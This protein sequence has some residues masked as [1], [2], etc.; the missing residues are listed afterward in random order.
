MYAVDLIGHDDQPELLFSGK[1]YAEMLSRA[2]EFEEYY[3]LPIVD[4][5]VGGNA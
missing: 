2:A 1:D 5:T 4:L 3:D